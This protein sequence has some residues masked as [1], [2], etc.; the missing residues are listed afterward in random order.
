MPNPVTGVM[1]EIPFGELVL[2]AAL[3]VA[4][5]QTA[6]DM[7]SIK[8][9][10][11]LATTELPAHSVILAIVEHVNEAG[12]VTEVKT[13]DNDAPMP[14]LVYGVEPTFYHFTE[15][16]I[17]LKFLVRLYVSEVEVERRSEFDRN[18]QS[19]FYESRKKYGGGGG[20]SLN[21]GFFSLG[22]GGGYSRTETNRTF[23]CEMRVISYNEYHSQVHSFSVQGAAHLTTTLKPKPLPTRFPE[24]RRL[25]APEPPEPPP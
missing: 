6:L 24:V 21:L 14:L 17:D 13:I 18:Y 23:R 16:I 11:V 19:S 15:T 7:N 25:A 3:A 1:Q 9:A 10:Q 22:G 20:L 4:N 8:T 12:D 2:Q 5:G